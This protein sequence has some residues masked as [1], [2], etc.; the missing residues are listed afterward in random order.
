MSDK[1][2]LEAIKLYIEEQE[3]VSDG[4]WGYARSLDELIVDGVMPEIYSEVIR[5]LR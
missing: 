3:V 1:E 2:F 4:E 5:R